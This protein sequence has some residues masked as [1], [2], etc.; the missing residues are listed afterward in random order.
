MEGQERGDYATL[1]TKS[2]MI[3]QIQKAINDVGVKP[4]NKKDDEN[5]S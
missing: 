3:D 5:P 2:D 4:E 1:G